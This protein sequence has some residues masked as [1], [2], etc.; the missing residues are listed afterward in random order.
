MPLIPDE[1]EEPILA[2][3]NII[4][5]E[6]EEPIN[7]PVEG[8]DKEEHVHLALNASMDITQEDKQRRWRASFMIGL[9]VIYPLFSSFSYSLFFSLNMVILMFVF[10]R[11]LQEVCSSDKRVVPRRFQRR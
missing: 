9:Q 8:L 2:G 11:D 3:A 4:P 1:D 10:L 6:K 7:A 5:E